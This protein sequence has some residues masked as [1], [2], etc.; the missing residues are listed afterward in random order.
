[1][2]LLAESLINQPP[3]STGFTLVELLVVLL[4]GAILLG[5]GVPAM[6]SLIAS[7]Q[8]AAVT[9]DFASAL[10]MARS[11]AGKLGTNVILTASGT[12]WG[13]GWTMTVTTTSATSGTSTTTT[14][15]TGAPVPPAYSLKSSSAFS[16]GLSFDSTG[17]LAG[18]IPDG[19]FVICQGSGPW[20]GGAARMISVTGSGRVRIAQNDASGTP[21]DMTTGSPIT[22]C[23]P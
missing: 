1:M 11:E 13:A 15:R 5:L 22:T 17:R 7:N 2:S 3:G 10:N 14:L 21:I 23:T 12:N 18:G 8:L 9:D 20:A 19:V 16:G 4:I 6:Q